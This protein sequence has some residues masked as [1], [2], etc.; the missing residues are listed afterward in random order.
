MNY[1]KIYNNI[2]EKAKN[3]SL[4]NVYTE[5]HHILP[6]SMGGSN[7][8]DNL[9][10]LT[11]KEH[12]VSHHLLWKIYKNREM[13]KAFMLMNSVKRDGIKFKVT[14]NTYQI[15]KEETS[16]RQSEFMLGKLSPSKGKKWSDE[17]KAKL[18]ASMMGHTRSKGKPSSFKG[19][20]HTDKTKKILSEKQKGK[21]NHLGVKHTEETKQQLSKNRLGKSKIPW[22]VYC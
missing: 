6:V 3:R 15:L 1:Q 11:A 13:T 14:A 8:K 4:Q 2:I 7:N 19:K 20:N 18:S 5:L 12:F 9:V 10:R 16:S 22:T 21:K 17:S